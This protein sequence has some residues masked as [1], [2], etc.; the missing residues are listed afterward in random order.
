MES[1]QKKK[2]KARKENDMHSTIL[3]QHKKHT[4]KQNTHTDT[5]REKMLGDCVLCRETPLIMAL[6][7]HVVKIS[8]VREDEALLV[9]VPLPLPHT[10]EL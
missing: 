3:H 7:V 10:H 1:N 2:Q 9:K 5:G 4:H 6:L 8:F